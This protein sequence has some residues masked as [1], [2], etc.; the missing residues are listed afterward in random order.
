M[1]Q[2]TIKVLKT[3]TEYTPELLQVFY[4][5]LMMENFSEEERE[6]LHEWE[7]MLRGEKEPGLELRLMLDSHGKVLAGAA[8]ESY[9]P[10]AVLLTYLVVS[11]ENRRK[12]LGT[13]L[14]QDL[15]KETRAKPEPPTIYLEAHLPDVPDPVMPSKSR[16]LF[17]SSL[18]F[19][20]LPVPYTAPALEP[21]LPNIAGLQ[22]LVY[23]PNEGLRTSDAATFLKTYWDACYSESTEDLDTMVRWLEG[24]GEW[25]P[26]DSP[27]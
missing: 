4:N 13:L 20:T 2:C 25:A 19:K 3:G 8:I 21:D 22:L 9:G 16:L 15:I 12:G 5:D 11:K 7:G 1:D 26:L 6:P 23:S 17:Y 10:K 14:C 24:K 18:G 27:C